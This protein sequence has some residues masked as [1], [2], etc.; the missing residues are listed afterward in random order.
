MSELFKMRKGLKRGEGIQS[1]RYLF[2]FLFFCVLNIHLQAQKKFTLDIQPTDKD[3]LYKPPLFFKENFPYKNQ[4]LSKSSIQK[5][6]AGIIEKMH[7]QFYLTASIDSL[8][9]KDSTYQAFLH[10][11]ATFKWANLENGNIDQTILDAVGFKTKFYQ[12]KP[13]DIKLVNQLKQ[14]V[15]TYAENNGYPFAR[16]WLDDLTFEGDKVSAK[17]YLDKKQLMTFDELAIE[18]EAPISRTYLVNYLGI[19]KGELYSE[20]LLKQ[21]RSRIS[22]LPFVKEK[23]SL[24]VIFSG[25]KAKVTLFLEK[26]NA[27]RFDFIVGVLP[28]NDITGRPIIT[29]SL[30]ADLQNPFGKGEAIGIDWQR[31]KA[32]TSRLKVAASY[33]YVLNLPFGLEGNLD[34][35]RRDTTLQDTKL[36]FGVQYLFQGNNYL[37]V[38]WK[39]TAN[40]V[41]SVNEQQII[42]TK[43]LPNNL[44]VLNTQLGLAY[45]YQRLNNRINP[46]K[47][48]AVQAQ[49][50][51]GIKQIRTNSAILNL[52]DENNPAFNF[53]SLYDSLSLKTF[54]I[55]SEISLA[56][57]YPLGNRMT[58][59]GELNGGL[60]FSQDSIYQNELYRIGGNRVLRGFDEES[61]LASS[62]G[63]L[64]IEPRF[65][66]NQNSYLFAFLDYAYL[67]NKSVGNRITDFPFGFG[68]GLSLGTPGGMVRMSY[69]IGRQSSNPIDFRAAK[70]HFGYVNYF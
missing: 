14:D 23:R 52:V 28:R 68:I 6:L 5:E 34:I 55:S 67:Q 44:D 50:G 27:S 66:L 59:K 40:N 58:I 41:L 46:Q 36:N 9:L 65:L 3:S 49:I 54:Q 4:H 57:Y 1:F 51:A 45:S 53:Q 43:K 16:I 20:S 29:G 7:N 31:L 18:G 39:S 69:A 21:V 2:V 35:Y 24:A 70:I 12:K 64:T 30:Q 11:G 42:N 62:Y 15:L 19:K 32:E 33:P 38:F 60:L 37:K 17:I 47:G 63:I 56:Y 25:D 48:Y 61:V 22:A 8:I 26:R 10:C 13:V